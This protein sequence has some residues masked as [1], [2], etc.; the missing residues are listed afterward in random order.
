MKKLTFFIIFSFMFLVACGTGDQTSLGSSD[1]PV[2]QNSD[3]RPGI[4]DNN[5]QSSSGM[6][7][8]VAH[9]TENEV[10]VT[11][12]RLTEP[13]E[14]I[15]FENMYDQAGNAISFNLKNID[16]QMQKSLI[17]GEK[18][19][20]TH[21][22]VAESYPGQSTAEA[23]RREVDEENDFIN[24]HGKMDNLH[25]FKQFLNDFYE[26]EN[27]EFRIVEYTIEGD[28]IFTTVSYENRGFQQFTDATQ[29][30]FGVSEQ[31]IHNSCGALAEF[32]EN[33]QVNIELEDCTNG[34]ENLLLEIDTN[35]ILVPDQTYTGLEI[36]VNGKITFETDDSSVIEDT[37][38][39]IKQGEKQ[40]LMSMSM[41]A[42]DGK[43]IIYGEQVDLIF[44]YYE[45]GAVLAHGMHI[46]AG[47]SLD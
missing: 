17:V 20:V 15:G 14:K 24:T 1:T 8:Y 11:D 5:D 40:S 33:K 16:K 29:D 35:D 31:I 32:Y 26:G 30:E 42:P 13:Y 27:S 39:K 28:P 22:A 25:I 12:K 41:M 9:I 46:A 10:I 37:L 47:L 6:V 45:A 19:V 7:G 4:N 23:I 38:E 18:I 2:G 21:N 34:Q 43:L 36:E 3:E 44:D